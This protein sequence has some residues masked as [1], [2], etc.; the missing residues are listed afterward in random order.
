M[1]AE[2]SD[3]PLLGL[4]LG[5]TLLV[6]QTSA[7]AL[8][9]SDTDT[10]AGEDN[11]EVHTIDTNL[12][13]VLQAEIDVLLDTETEVTSRGEALVRELELL[14]TGGKKERE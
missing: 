3:E 4:L 1:T 6:A 14:L 13:I 12:R 5:D 2:L 10:R 8:T 7:T 9:L 11:V